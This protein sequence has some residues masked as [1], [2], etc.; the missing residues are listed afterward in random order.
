MK[1]III[2]YF[3]L[4]AIPDVFA[5]T[6]ITKQNEKGLYGFADE[7]GNFIIKP[8]YDKVHFDFYKGIACVVK[9]K[10]YV[11][12]NTS[13]K[14][15]SKSYS[16]ASYFDDNNLCLV[17]AGGKLDEEGN[18]TGGKYGYVDL[19]GDERIAVRY[20]RIGEFNEQG[21]ALIN[22]GGS[23]NNEGDFEGGKNG[24]VHTSGKILISPKYTFVGEFTE[25]G[26]AW[27][28]VGGKYDETGN[29]I[30]GKF[31][32]VDKDGIEIIAPK[33]DFIGPIGEDGFYWINKGGKI[34]K[35]DKR[36]ET[37]VKAYAAKEKDKKKVA[38]Y[39]EVFENE[40]L[41]AKRDILGQKIFGGKFGF[42]DQSGKEIVPVKYTKTS[43]AFVEGIIRATNNKK[44]GFID[45]KGREITK[46]IYDQ[47]FDFHNGVA[48]VGLTKK[49]KNRYG[50]VNKQGR[51]ITKIEYEEIGEMNHGFT[52]LKT[53]NTYDKKT[54]SATLSKYGFIDAN[55]KLLTPIIYHNI[56]GIS[57]GMA[58]CQKYPVENDTLVYKE[59][60]NGWK[61]L[62]T[63]EIPKPINLKI[64]T[65]KE[66]GF[67]YLDSTGQEITPFIFPKASKF[68]SG[69]AIVA[70]NKAYTYSNKK[71]SPISASLN[72]FAVK[73]SI[74]VSTDSI[75]N[76]YYGLI[77][78]KGIALTDFVYNKMNEPHEGA[79]AV[80]I[81][82]K[83]GWLNLKGESII[84]LE[85]S[86]AGDFYGGVASVKLSDKWG[87]INKKG[88][89]V[90]DCKYDDITMGFTEG[91]AGVKIGEF[92]GGINK[93]GEVIVPIKL[94][95]PKDLFEIYQSHNIEQNHLPIT[96]R[97]IELYYI[98]KK[99]LE[100]HFNISTTIPNEYWDY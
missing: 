54:K 49:Y 72:N 18:P 22:E 71:G 78:Q 50:L 83:Y 10:K 45:N 44:Y 34:F 40:F 48:K 11:F 79:I 70:L 42:A 25:N 85:Y 66:L 87:Y 39:R 3:V 6:L 27:V 68:L 21:V 99:N 81:N 56:A 59:K 86:G 38:V 88:Q 82:D 53:P 35:S 67:G 37:E 5:Q 97:D 63:G 33:Y 14:E 32:Y 64:K 20:A 95:S 55:G 100:Q 41:G 2:W 47:A 15:I 8:K 77:N 84:P 93:K 16:W 60:L 80:A 24:F 17:N 4:M 36:V 31:G 46:F 43:D 51:E 58:M 94:S 98:H 26:F 30:G 1:Y 90:V 89:I 7:T 74:S 13:G 76:I 61:M 23:I 75:L 92:W 65:S 69:V 29:L 52:Y 73:D 12:I 9:G 96:E 19:N 28:N 57:D 62:K 91:I